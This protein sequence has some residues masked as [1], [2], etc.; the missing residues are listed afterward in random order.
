[1][2]RDLYDIL[3]VSKNADIK[4]I[5]K[6]YRKIARDNHPDLNPDDEAAEERFKE[7]STAFEVLSDSEKRELY[8]EFGLDGLREGFDPEQA[9]QYKRWQQQAGRGGFRGYG[10]GGGGE[11]RDSASFQDIFGS[12][13]GGRSPFDTSDYSDFGGFYTGPMKGADLEAKLTLDFMTA[14]KGGELEIRVAGRSIKVRIPP[15]AADGDK[16]R[17]KGKGRPAPPQAPKG[18]AG[19]LLLSIEV[20]PHP[21]LDREGLDLLLEFPVTIRE[22]VEGAKLPVPTPHGEF[23][24]TIPSGVDSGAKLRL[25]G[26]GVHRGSRKGDFFVVIQIKSPDRIDDDVLDL[27]EKLDASYTDDVRK[28]LEI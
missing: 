24:V 7:A 20:T 23:K 17:L 27:V 12:V 4:E 2:E 21:H 8:D 13:F 16:L 19:D 3:G 11:F 22:A 6:A 1:M 10:G 9:R 18:K 26:Q 14:V 15:G 5:K 25:K 28:D